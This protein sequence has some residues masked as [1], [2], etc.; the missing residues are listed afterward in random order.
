MEMPNELRE[1]TTIMA[2]KID[3]S[4]PKALAPL[5]TVGPKS[6]LKKPLFV[7]SGFFLIVS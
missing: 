7:S 2:R 1:G 4:S 6:L 5:V 3:D